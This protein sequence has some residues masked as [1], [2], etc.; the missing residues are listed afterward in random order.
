M[1]FVG[2]RLGWE[3]VANDPSA[4]EDRLTYRRVPGV[5]LIE[6]VAIGRVD[7]ADRKRLALELGRFIGAVSRL[8]PD[9]IGLTVP[10]DGGGWAEWFDGWDQHVDVV[11]SL[12]DTGLTMPFDGSRR[13]RHRGNCRSTGSRSPTT[14]WEPSTYWSIPTR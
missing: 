4:A 11:A 1:R 7:S 10:I 3:W 2:E 5:P 12:V 9:E 6:L 13:R 8:D 14:T